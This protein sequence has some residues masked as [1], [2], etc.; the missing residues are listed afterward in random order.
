[1]VLGEI[2]SAHAIVR[3]VL[4]MLGGGFAKNGLSV[5]R[6]RHFRYKHLFGGAY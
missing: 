3:T 1:M 5:V 6:S 2:M 4:I